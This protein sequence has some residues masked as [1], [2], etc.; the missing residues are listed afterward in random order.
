M[1]GKASIRRNSEAK[2]EGWERVCQ[3]SRGVRLRA[4]LREELALSRHP[5]VDGVS[6]VEEEKVGQ[7][8]WNVASKWKVLTD[9]VG[10]SIT[11]ASHTLGFSH[12]EIISCH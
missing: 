1:S 3:V 9:K 6:K 8:D 11:G 2:S 12:I 5:A 7:C 4:S 10:D